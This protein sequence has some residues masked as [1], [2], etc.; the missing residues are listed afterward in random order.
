MFL[1]QNVFVSHDAIFGNGQT[2]SNFNISILTLL[3]FVTQKLIEVASFE[4][5][6]NHYRSN[7]LKARNEGKFWSIRSCPFKPLLQT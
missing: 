6:K 4:I 7:Y 5:I 1:H 3:H 2:Y